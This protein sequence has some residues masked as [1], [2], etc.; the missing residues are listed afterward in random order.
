MNNQMNRII[1][2]LLFLV[3]LF[4]S[5]TGCADN[6]SNGEMVVTD[7]LGREVSVSGTIETAVCIGPGALRLYSYVS[8]IDKLC[9][10]EQIELDNPMGRPYTMVYSELTELTIIGAG[11]PANAP[12]AEQLLTVAPDVIFSTYAKE[13]SAA[14]ELQEKTGI[15]VIAVSY[16]TTAPFDDTLNQSLELI[17]TVMH[18]Q[19][20]AQEVVSFINS[21]KDDL[22]S[23]TADI[24]DTEKVSVYYGA[25]SYKG[26]HGIEST[27]GGYSL[28]AAINT[29]SVVDKDGISGYVMLDKEQL[30]A[31]DP[32]VI[33][34][35]LGGVSLVQEDYTNNPNY[36]AALSAFTSGKVYSQLPY[37]Y[38]SANID[39]A[40]IDAYYMGMVLYPDRFSDITIEEIAEDVFETMLGENVYDELVTDFG[41]LDQLTFH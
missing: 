23:R 9:G 31:W 19:E 11:G 13:S 14:D 12:D 2:I 5:I 6:A 15:P 1:I 32:Q 41:V 21:C 8:E 22:N 20:R 33:F 17:G 38:Y 40:I 35:D 16:G 29:Q 27:T 3:V 18:T 28:F 24:S 7:M 4:S 25:Q 10:V 39:V 26:M 36:Y 34:I 37:N 30:L